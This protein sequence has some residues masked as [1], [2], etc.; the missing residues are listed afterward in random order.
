VTNA[1]R[2]ALVLGG[3]GLVVW[4]ALG[5]PTAQ[6]AR[7]TAAQADRLGADAERLRR[8]MAEEEQ[9]V[10]A[11][12]R[13]VAAL[14][15]TG[16]GPDAVTTMRSGLLA[17]LRETRLGGVHLAV[18]PRAR[19][20]SVHVHGSGTF[21]DTITALGRLAGPGSGLSLERVQLSASE[22]RITMDVSGA[23]LVGPP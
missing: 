3:L 6:D 11:R 5:R 2:L 18:S 22:D 10:A 20:S 12:D 23:G 9:R 13:A 19:G 21:A 15:L 8:Q 7:A 17:A 1:L 4:L 16:A 14:T